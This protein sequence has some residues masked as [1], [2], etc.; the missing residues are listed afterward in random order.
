MRA[1][2]AVLVAGFAVSCQAFA[3]SGFQ[4]QRAAVRLHVRQS[5]LS[6]VEKV[7]AEV[8][9]P[10]KKA[11]LE[12]K[13]N[14]L[15]DKKNELVDS[16]REVADSI[17]A[18]SWNLKHS[19]L[20]ASAIQKSPY[21]MLRS[22]RHSDCML[23]SCSCARANITSVRHSCSGCMTSEDMRH[24]GVC[25]QTY[26]VSKCRS[27][28][29]VFQTSDSC[30]HFAC[31]QGAF[32]DIDAQTLSDDFNAAVEG[33]KNNFKAGKVGERGEVA[34][35]VPYILLFFV[36]TGDLP[37]FGDTLEFL[38]GPGLLIFGVSLYVASIIGLGKPAYTIV[39]LTWHGRKPC[40]NARPGKSDF[41][42]RRCISHVADRAA[43]VH[44]CITGKNLSPWQVPAEGN[45]LKT[46]GAYSLC[47]HPMYTG[48]IAASLG[49]G[50]AT[51]STP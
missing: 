14:E 36:L 41:L 51:V 23:L 11:V 25:C 20:L 18:R 12:A 48:I 29:I 7:D 39:L 42:C 31:P 5:T 21:N 33:V 49:L 44:V 38:A 32:K 6:M 17:K 10:Q 37:I 3:P 45:V 46:T 24:K 16:A 28:N 34:A 35:L 47:R 50:F 43:H 26:R 4:L 9:S 22:D 27:S 2:L 13:K 15:V 1:I 30:T 19:V 8:I 40:S